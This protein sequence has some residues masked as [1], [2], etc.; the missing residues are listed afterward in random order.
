MLL[1]SCDVNWKVHPLIKLSNKILT[2]ISFTPDRTR[3]LTRVYP[4]METPQ[5]GLPAYH[6]CAGWICPLSSNTVRTRDLTLAVYRTQ[7]KPGRSTT[8]SYLR[9]LNYLSTNFPGGYQI[10]CSSFTLILMNIISNWFEIVWYFISCFAIRRQLVSP[11]KA[12]HRH[13]M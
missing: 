2:N 6:I 8:R 7:E 9:R 11:F 5:A 1:L 13:A 10:E 3:D 12:I 4:T